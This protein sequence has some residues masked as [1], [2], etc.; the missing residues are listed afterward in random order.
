ML[1]REHDARIRRKTSLSQQVVR[2]LARGVQAGA[3]VQGADRKKGLHRWRV[4]VHLPC[5]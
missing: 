1:A 3:C 4:G 5:W 2:Y